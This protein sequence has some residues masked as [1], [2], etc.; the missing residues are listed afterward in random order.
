VHPL[1]PLTKKKKTMEDIDLRSLARGYTTASVA[2]LGAWATA[3][4]GVDDDIKIR[5]IGML[6]DRGWG[7]PNQPTEN[8][9]EGEVNII[10]RDMM[11]E[12]AKKK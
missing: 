1:K 12:R 5:A 4:T 2:T 9:I 6:L 8:K 11:A 7:K 3:V 10:L